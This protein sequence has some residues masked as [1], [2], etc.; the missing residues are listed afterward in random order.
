MSHRIV[1]DKPARRVSCACGWSA[2]ATSGKA[3]VRLGNE[4][5]EKVWT[6]GVCGLRVSRK[7]AWNLWRRP[8]GSGVVSF[9]R[10]DHSE[11]QLAWPH[12]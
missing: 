10:F 9:G 5:V 2:T 8:D 6:C 12:G 3:A 7:S 4:H 1:T 11:L